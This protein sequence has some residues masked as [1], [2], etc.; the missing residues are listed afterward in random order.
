MLLKFLMPFLSPCLYAWR[1]FS[2]FLEITAVSSWGPD[3]ML[4]CPCYGI[5]FLMES[6]LNSLTVACLLSESLAHLIFVSILN[7]SPLYLSA[8]H[9]LFPT[10]MFYFLTSENLAI[11]WVLSHDTLFLVRGAGLLCGRYKC[12][13]L[14]LLSELPLFPLS[15]ICLGWAQSP[16]FAL[17][18]NTC[19]YSSL[20]VMHPGVGRKL[21]WPSGRLVSPSGLAYLWRAYH[22]SGCLCLLELIPC[23]YR[24]PHRSCME[25]RDTHQ[26]ADSPC[27]AL[28]QCSNPVSSGQKPP[29]IPAWFHWQRLAVFFFSEQISPQ[30]GQRLGF[31]SQ[32]LPWPGA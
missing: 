30:L 21:R 4:S 13:G 17:W 23:A 10:W 19:V 26:A 11:L 25:K 20:N 8:F 24:S 29:T 1:E 18:I 14:C 3:L 16:P 32:T 31:N 7:H 2:P 5:Y 15:F 22:I 6:L 28:V 12:W 27:S 9:L